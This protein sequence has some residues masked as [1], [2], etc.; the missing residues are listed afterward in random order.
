DRQTIGYISIRLKDSVSSQLF[1]I[2]QIDDN[3]SVFV[4]NRE[5]EV[6]IKKG[7]IENEPKSYSAVKY[8]VSYQTLDNNLVFTTSIRGGL[9]KIIK[10]VPLST[11]N[12]VINRLFLIGLSLSIAFV[13]LAIYLSYLFSA[14]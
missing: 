6:L 1:N 3:S 4:L 10:V 12:S 7:N 11:I 14:S 13:M 2:L 8:D 9:L 5:D